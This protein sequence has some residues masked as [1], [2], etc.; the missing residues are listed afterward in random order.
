MGMKLRDI[1]R[2]IRKIIRQPQ[3]LSSKPV[4]VMQVIKRASKNN[5]FS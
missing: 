3:L 4:Q 5:T 1:L 2:E